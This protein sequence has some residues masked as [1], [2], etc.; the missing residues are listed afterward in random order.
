MASKFVI[1]GKFEGNILVEGRTGCGKTSFVQHV[2]VNNIFSELDTI[3]WVSQTVLS[4]RR[5][6]QI[7][8]CS[9][10]PVKFHYL[11]SVNDSKN[12]IGQFKKKQRKYCV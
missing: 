8:S 4:E 11:N 10:S 3:E 5:E 12:L 6:V 2:A 7:Q 1:G 9:S